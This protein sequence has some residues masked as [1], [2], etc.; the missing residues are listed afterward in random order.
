MK[1]EYGRNKE[2]KKGRGFH[3][4]GTRSPCMRVNEWMNECKQNAHKIILHTV[5]NYTLGSHA[6]WNT[7]C[8]S[9]SDHLN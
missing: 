2:E 1:R 4:T 9:E 6:V 8:F 5:Y 3:G 7:L